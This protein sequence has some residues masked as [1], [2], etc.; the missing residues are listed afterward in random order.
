LAAVLQEL[1]HFERAV[2]AYGSALSAYRRL[3]ETVPDF[4]DYVE[5]IAL[6]LLDRAQLSCDLRR[7][8]ECDRDLKEALPL[9]RRLKSQFPEFPVHQQELAAALDAQGRYLHIVGEFSDARDALQQ[10]LDLFT[11]LSQDHPL[12]DYRQ[13]A[14]AVRIQLA[15]TLAALQQQEA[16]D[17]QFN[18]AQAELNE[19]RTLAPGHPRYAVDMAC[20]HLR[21]GSV[22]WERGELRTAKAEYQQA[23]Q[24]WGAVITRWPAPSHN[25][26]LADLLTTCPVE[27]VR[28]SKQAAELA[29]QSLDLAPDE[30]LVRSTAALAFLRLGKTQEALNLDGFQQ[31]GLPLARDDFAR[32]LAAHSLG[33]HDRAVQ[34]FNQGKRL[35]SQQ[36]G[37]DDLRRLA[38][39]VANAVNVSDSQ[40]KD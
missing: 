19:L 27:D 24:D 23:I 26:A 35:Q 37:D 33:D 7:L 11:Q 10:S 30:P 3:H 16:A 15:C 29:R 1:G 6:A 8:P 21:R 31:A 13:R 20:L 25:R 38:A 36:V 2:K 40:K 28:N 32:A 14:A 9:I 34:Y 5:R 22:Y 17:K 39:E 12:P 18:E 4:A